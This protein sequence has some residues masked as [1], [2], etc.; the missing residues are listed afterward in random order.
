MNNK[1]YIYAI[2]A[3]TLALSTS[4]RAQS[5]SVATNF[6][7]WAELATLNVEVGYAW[8]QHLSFHA[9]VYYN[10]FTFGNADQDDRYEE[11]VDENRKMFQYKREAVAIGARWWPWHV[12]SGWWVRGKLQLQGYDRGGVFNPQRY[13][14]TA[15]G[16]GVGIGYA[17]MFSQNWNIDFGITGWAGYTH[18]NVY[19]RV[20]SAKPI[21]ERNRFFFLPDE[22]TLSLVYIF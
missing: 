8:D 10:P 4:I 17:W 18:E 14:G 15:F 2:L 6:G 5:F 9:G 7:C 22:L 11:I 21:E 13:Q 19:E 3:V 12:F 20:N 16:A 1:R